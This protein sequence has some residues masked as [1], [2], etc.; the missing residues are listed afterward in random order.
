MSENIRQLERTYEA[1]PTCYNCA[2]ESKVKIPYGTLIAA[3]DWKCDKCG[4]SKSQVENYFKSHG[5][6]LVPVQ[7]NGGLLQS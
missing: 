3:H 2:K 1:T 6:Q 7:P 5:P 4:C